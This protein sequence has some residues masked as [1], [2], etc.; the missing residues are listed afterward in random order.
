MTL[1]LRTGSE[2]GTIIPLMAMVMLTL[3][4]FL[5]LSMRRFY[6]SRSAASKPL[7]MLGQS[8]ALKNCCVSTRAM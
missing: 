8:L 5:G 1:E 7:R 2:R 4:A 3:V 6:I